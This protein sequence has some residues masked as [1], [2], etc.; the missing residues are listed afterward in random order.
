[1]S[2]IL[3]RVF[4]TRFD[5]INTAECEFEPG[6]VWRIAQGEFA[7]TTLLIV[8]VDILS[9]IGLGVHVSVRGPLMVDGEPFLDGIPHLPFSPDAM[10]VSDLEF[11]GFLS[12]MPDDWEEM[13]FDWED[14]ALAGEAGYFSLPVSEILLT[15]LGKLSQILK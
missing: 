10:R 2:D 12:N 14:D 4:S 3:N 13:Y 8:K 15:I 6:Q 9:P 7:G 1:M 5:T 11:T